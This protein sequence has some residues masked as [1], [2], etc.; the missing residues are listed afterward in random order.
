MKADIPCLDWYFATHDGAIEI[1]E[2]KFCPENPVILTWIFAKCSLK[3][4][5]LSRNFIL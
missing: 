5:E 1:L 3:T 4:L 2:T